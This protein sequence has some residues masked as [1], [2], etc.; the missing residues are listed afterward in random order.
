MSVENEGVIARRP[1]PVTDDPTLPVS[2]WYVQAAVVGDGTGGHARITLELNPAGTSR[3]ARSWSLETSMP[4]INGATVEQGVMVR[5]LGLDAFGPTREPIQKS[6][7]Q[8][9][10]L[11][12]DLTGQ[13]KAAVEGALMHPRLYLGMQAR[14]GIAASL[15][16][17][18]QNISARTYGIYAS[19]YEWGPEAISRGA[20]RFPWGLLG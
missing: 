19:G 14:G 12:A 16:W 11:V 7:T 13:P 4:T 2:V 8:L 6:F 15:R 3:S 17:E 9:C 10:V 20:R 18:F 1:F 5:T